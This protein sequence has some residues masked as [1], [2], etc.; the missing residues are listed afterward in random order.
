MIRVL[1]VV[2]KYPIPVVGGLERQ[3]FELSRALVQ[4]PSVEVHVLTTRFDSAHKKNELVDGVQIKR[5]KWF[6]SRVLRHLILPFQIALEMW[7]FRKSINVVHVHQH[8]TF[9]LFAIAI[10]RLLGLQVI[11]KL[12]NVGK[13]GVPGIRQGILGFFSIRVFLL[14]NAFVA[15]SKE[16]VNE[17][18]QIGVPFSRILT[19]PNGIVLSS[20]NTTDHKNQAI[21]ESTTCRVVFVGRLKPQKRLDILLRAWQSLP[22]QTRRLATLEIWGDGPLRVA[23]EEWCRENGLIE[24]IVWRGNLT[25][26][27]A[28]LVKADIFV[29]PSSNEGNSNAI[30]EA[31]DA[32]VPV[33]AT[34][35]GGTEMQLGQAG[36]PYLVEVGDVQ[37]IANRLLI[38]INNPE[39]RLSYGHELR[40]RASK[41]FDLNQIA[42]G[43]LCAYHKI[44]FSLDSDVSKCA[45]LPPAQT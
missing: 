7:Y 16:S 44:V 15:M 42:K 10:S 9:G 36:G 41:Y 22:E 43:Y 8:S 21:K 6:K 33:L 5:V 11:V 31:M 45:T 12:P 1:M 23:L 38:L 3:A 26:V 35:V 4:E 13:H 17:L 40:E 27:R 19:I 25:D 34:S 39:L 30:L 28:E 2:P 18:K 14:A 29:L 32:S 24:S 20:P 37:A